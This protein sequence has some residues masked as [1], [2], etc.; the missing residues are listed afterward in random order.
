MYM[1]FGRE[2]GTLGRTG[3]CRS[4]LPTGTRRST[5]TLR[6]ANTPKSSPSTM[7]RTPAFPAFIS[8]CRR[9]EGVAKLPN[10]Y[11]EYDLRGQKYLRALTTA[12]HGIVKCR[13]LEAK[14]I[15][16]DK[17]HPDAVQNHASLLFD[18]R[19]EENDTVSRTNSDSGSLMRKSPV[20]AGALTKHEKDREITAFSSDCN[21]MLCAMTTHRL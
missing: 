19:K 21:R 14:L 7:T 11:D 13:N 2:K 6:P 4:T 17:P 15:D 9:K 10:P 18:R 5:G 3:F 16:L 8:R 1:Y 20:H 12:P